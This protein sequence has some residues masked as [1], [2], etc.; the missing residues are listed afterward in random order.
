MNHMLGSAVLAAAA[1]GGPVHAQDAATGDAPTLPAITVTTPR[2]VG[3][4]FD[5]A[6]SVDRVDGAQLRDHKLQVNLSESLGSVPGLQVQNRQNYAQDL[7]LSV[8]GFGARSTFGVRGVRIYVDGI[9]ATLPD[10]QGQTSN[11]DIGSADRV[12]LLRGPFS[13]LY[14]NSSGGVMQVFTESG[15]GA[16]Q[17]GYSFAAG[18]NGVLRQSLK[19]GGASGAVDYLLSGSHFT[20][21]GWR[22]RSAAT[23]DIA[24]GKLGIALDNGDKLTIVVNSVHLKAQDPLGLTADQFALAPRSSPLA[25]QYDTRKTVDQTQLGMLYERRVDANNDLRVML[26]TG[27]RSTT[28][29][30]AIPAAAQQNPLQAGGVIDLQRRY[31]GIDVRWSS[32]LQVADR[33][34]ELVAGLAY[35]TLRE[36]RTGYEN[37]LGRV[38][39]PLL[40]VQGR[41]RRDERNTVWNLDPYVQAT[42]RLTDRWT[43]EAGVRRSSVHFDSQDRYVIGANG[44][45][46]GSARYSR[47]LP[48]A[49]L[50]YQATPDLALYTSAGRGFETP[51]L[52]ELSY[53]ANGQSGLNFA[54]QPSVNDSV[55]VGAK[56]RVSGGLLTAALFR[57]GTRDEIVTNTN[58]GGRATFQNA[59][60]TRRD[61]FEAAWLHETENHW[62][63]QLAYTWLDARY[64]DAFCSPS[65]CGTGNTIAAGNRIPGIAQQSLF[66][67]FGWVPPEG[68]R[69]GAELRALGRIQA[70]DVNTARAAGYAVAAL[71]AGYVKRWDRW[72]FNAFARIDN[73][74]DRRYAGSVIVN[75][76]NARYYEPALGRNWTVGMG[77]T[78]RF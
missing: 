72:E 70:N 36:A 39:A 65:P 68:W 31:G 21:D 44:N 32:R 22:E 66:A 46:S 73:L 10:G 6:G 67:A 35:D 11:I 23:R 60:R 12:E 30:Q 69:A 54:L 78:Y 48:V 17:L 61:G 71:H 19:L 51:T 41:L 63:T 34:F 75:E 50:R 15:E 2:G 24:N 45:D 18:S 14:G 1:F 62:R 4:A 9:P 76:G 3:S 7:Q 38:S 55:E 16:P 26:Y 49:S 29:Y 8:R 42:W 59:G 52:N 5:V 64:R 53:R 58:V 28:Q 74:F 77:G 47:T 40:G 20:T 13:A 25:V 27:E 56:A 33:P 37:Y 57:T 43:V